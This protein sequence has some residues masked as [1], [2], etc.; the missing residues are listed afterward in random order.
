M[1]LPPDA[2]PIHPAT[3]TLKPTISV[4]WIAEQEIDD[5]SDSASEK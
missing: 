5:L 2:K 3:V 4:T 1:T